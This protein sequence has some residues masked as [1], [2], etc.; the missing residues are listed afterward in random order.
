MSYVSKIHDRMSEGRGVHDQV[1]IG[2]TDAAVAEWQSLGLRS[3]DMTQLR[4][5]RLH[6]VVEQISERDL[7]GVLLFDPMN[8]RYASD[9]SNMQVWVLHNYCR[10]CLVLASGEMVLWDFHGCEHLSAHLPLISE[11]RHGASFIYFES[12]DRLQEHADRF[13][14]DLRQVLKNYGAGDNT[15]LA[16]DK[17]EIIGNKALE[18]QGIQIEFGQELMELARTVKGVE[19]LQAMRCAVVACERA[20][21]EMQAV[22]KPGISENE[23]WAELHKGNIKRGGEWIET[24]LLASGP[25]TNP[26]F[27]EC[28]P[29]IIEA[30]DMVGFDTDMVGVYGYCVDISRTWLCGDGEA[31]R[32]QRELYKIAYEHIQSN[33]AIL[34][35][36]LSYEQACLQ[37]RR[38]PELYR[39]QRYSCWAHGVGL[40]DE[41]PCFRYQEDWES[42]GYDGCLEENMVLSV[43]AYVGA[44]G[45]R[46][47]VKLEEQVLITADG[48]EV[49]SSYPF[50]A[51]LL[52]D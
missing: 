2:P 40:C 46:E 18:Q 14:R 25:R 41:Y 36:G 3:P 31:S 45:G 23:L 35:P 1:E 32:E 12:G 51:R 26:W 47:G 6:R 13:A 24:R 4:S 29:R 21:A 10:A 42:S 17:I 8:I 48:A 37:S 15:R 27:Q 34:R 44:P 9:C 19:E 7:A 20:M 33:I 11:V 16:V 5:Y 30:G 43:E 50:E 49:M 39:S 22:L 52:L 38:L 28:G